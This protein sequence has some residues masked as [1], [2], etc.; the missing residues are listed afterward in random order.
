MTKRRGLLTA[1]IILDFFM[2]L[3]FVIYMFVLWSD[4][5]A[6]VYQW[7]WTFVIFVVFLMAAAYAVFGGMEVTFVAK[8]GAQY[9]RRMRTLL[10]FSIAKAAFCLAPFLFL[11][12][13]NIETPLFFLMV[14]LS[15]AVCSF[16]AY[17]MGRDEQEERPAEPA[18]PQRGTGS[19]QFF[20]IDPA[21]GVP[22]S[23]LAEREKKQG[24]APQ[25]PAPA[26]S[27]NEKLL[28][29]IARLNDLRN[30]GAVSEEEFQRLK[31]KL[32]D[33]EQ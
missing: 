16:I 21:T 32:L 18:A 4:S 6:Y 11:W 9:A 3:N 12:I 26:D 17:S 33:G 2:L 10:G 13:F 20:G 8:T 25:E 14:Q 30:S 29:Q 7:Q 5:L 28:E 31:A 27:A 15:G 23:V 22:Y 24:E 1:A 19:T